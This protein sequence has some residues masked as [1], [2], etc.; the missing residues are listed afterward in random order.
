VSRPPDVEFLVPDHDGGADEELPTPARKPHSRA[1]RIAF[2][3]AVLVV[4]AAAGRGAL[5]RSAAP[6]PAAV[7][8]TTVGPASASPSAA[9][10]PPAV[11]TRNSFQ[12]LIPRLITPTP[13]TARPGCR[14]VRTLPAAFHAAVRAQ[15]LGTTTVTT[16][17]LVGAQNHRL[18]SREYTG[19]FGVTVLHVV[20][21]PG[22]IRGSTTS[23]DD[24]IWVRAASWCRSGSAA[25]QVFA[26]A[27]SGHDP[28]LAKLSRLCGDPRLL[29]VG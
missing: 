14:S 13:C 11:P 17:S 8:T 20:V 29:A 4:G 15:F 26:S 7:A 21:T 5:D 3:A 12:P 16:V 27:P 25:I 24:G 18:W 1:V 28:T 19:R 6:T 9:A 23:F 22:G 10:P 2:A